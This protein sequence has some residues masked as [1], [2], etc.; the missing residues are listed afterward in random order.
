MLQKRNYLPLYI[1]LISWFTINIIQAALIGVD[2][3][4]AYYWMFSKNLDWGFFDHP[5]F[6][7]ILIKFG[8]SFGHSPIYTRL[9]TVILTTATAL[10]IFIGLPDRLKHAKYFALLFPSILIINVYGFITTPDA[11]LFFF[12]ALFFVGYK[13]YLEKENILTVILISFAIT[14]MFYSKYHGIL[15]VIFVLLSNFQLLKRKSFW[16]IILIV[17]F[18]YIPHMYW[19]FQHDWPTVRFH[20]FER[21]LRRYKINF[22]L[23][24]ILGQLLIW[25]PIISFFFYYKAIKINNEEKIIKAHV[26]NFWGVLIVF[27]LSSFKNHVEA[28]WTLVAGT[29]FIVLFMDI[30]HK[31]DEKRKAL[32]ITLAK[33][34][35][36]FILTLRILLLVPGVPIDKIKNYKPFVHGKSWADSIYKYAG[37]TPV[38]FTD[39]YILP[40]IYNYYHPSANAIGY[41]T[42]Y[43]RKTQYSINHAEKE[44]KGKNVLWFNDSISDTV[45]Q[46]VSSFKSGNLI[47]INNY[48]SIND[49]KIE[50]KKLPEKIQRNDTIDVNLIIRNINNDDITN[51]GRLSISYSFSKYSYIVSEGANTFELPKG[52]LTAR[53]S[54]TMPVKIIAPK[55]KG[56]TRLLFSINNGILPGNFASRYYNIKIE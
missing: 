12:S 16:L 32:F 30:I 36:V 17:V 13:L 48:C 23:D 6:V 25:G 42:K 51:D 41:N 4:E 2:G 5:P 7:A 46:I 54:I 56:S 39:S 37:T 40:A 55:E 35:I 33:I 8:E 11:P 38:V 47:P 31:A 44:L 26:F 15:P 9:G 1:F 34:N 45:P 27:L 20:L 3:D 43:Y 29:S 21:G 28:H 53:D 50:V 19:Q 14:G 10:I 49:F 52:I 24:Y 22:T 18:L